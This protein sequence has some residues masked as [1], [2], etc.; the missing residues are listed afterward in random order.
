[1]LTEQVV[2]QL[3]NRNPYGM[4]M[5]KNEYMESIKDLKR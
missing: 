2:K 1:M 5:K 4:T 3:S